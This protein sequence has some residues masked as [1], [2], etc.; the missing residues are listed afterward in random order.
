[1]VLLVTFVELVTGAAGL[2]FVVFAGD[3]LMIVYV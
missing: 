2:G 3:R 1:M